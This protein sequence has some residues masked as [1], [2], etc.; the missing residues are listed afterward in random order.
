MKRK[1][2]TQA[3][4]PS[5]QA[6]AMERKLKTMAREVRQLAGTLKAVGAKVDFLDKVMLAD[7]LPRVSEVPVITEN[8]RAQKTFDDEARMHVV[9]FWLI[10]WMRHLVTTE[11]YEQARLQARILCEQ[12]L[13]GK[14]LA[15]IAQDIGRDVPPVTGAVQ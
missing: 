7:V 15:E 10:I 13:K 11:E 9:M 1:P 2:K 4:Q 5:K 8:L 12:I 6:E 3:V 14:S